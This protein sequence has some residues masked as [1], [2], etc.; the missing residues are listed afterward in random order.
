[1]KLP[2]DE[3]RR[4]KEQHSLVLFRQGIRSKQTPGKYDDYDLMNLYELA[5]NC[6]VLTE[7]YMKFFS[8]IQQ[9]IGIVYFIPTVNEKTIQFLKTMFNHSDPDIKKLA[10][11]SFAASRG[12]VQDDDLARQIIQLM[13]TVNDSHIG[14]YASALSRFRLNWK[15]D[16]SAFLGFLTSAKNTEQQEGWSM[17]ISGSPAILDEDRESYLEFL[18][19]I[20]EYH[21]ALSVKITTMAYRQIK[22]IIS[23][24]QPSEID[25]KSLNLPLREIR[26]SF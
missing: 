24:E 17:L 19:S 22:S 15:R 26:L 10:A 12:I 21:P 14:A 11:I 6:N 1:M 20:L 7:E 9:K 8:S 5:L 3:F 13:Q 25:E 4:S 18:Y 16:G 2:K 23:H